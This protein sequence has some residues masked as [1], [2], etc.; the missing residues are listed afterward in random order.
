MTPTAAYRKVP[1]DQAKMASAAIAIRALVNSGS[2]TAAAVA[3]DW[4][5]TIQMNHEPFASASTGRRRWPSSAIQG[6]R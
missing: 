1:T 6:T 5:A 4:L 2:S 3:T